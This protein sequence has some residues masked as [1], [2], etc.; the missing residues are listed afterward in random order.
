MNRHETHPE[1][2][3]VFDEAFARA[4]LLRM[5]RADVNAVRT[6]HYPPHPRVLDLCDELGFWVVLECDLETHGFVFVDWAGNPSDDPAWADGVPRPHRADGRA[7]QEPRQRR[8]WSLGN[9]AGTGSQPRRHG[10]LGAPPRPEPARALRGRP[11]LHLHRRLLADVPELPR[12]RGDRRRRPGSSPTCTGRPRRM[13]VRARPLVLCEYAHAMGNGP[14][15]VRHLRRPVRA[16]TPACTAGSSGSGATTGS[17]DARPPTAPPYYAYGGDFGEV[18]HDGNFVMDGMV[19]PDGTPTPG[20]AEWRAVNAPVRL[21]RRRV[22]CSVRNRQHSADTAGLRF[23]GGARGGRPRGRRV[24]IDAMPVEA[25][26][27]RPAGAARRA[28]GARAETGETWLTVRAELAHDTPWAPAGHV[29]ARAQCDLTPTAAAVPSQ[30][31]RPQRCARRRG[32]RRSRSVRPSST[33]PPA[34]SRASATSPSRARAWSCGGRPPTTTAATSAARTSSPPPRTPRRGRPA[35][36]RTSAGASA[37]WTGWCTASARVEVGRRPVV[38]RP[39]RRRPQ[40]LGV[41]VTYR[42]RAPRRRGAARRGAARPRAG[43]A[44][45]P[46]SASG[47]T[48]RRPGPGRWFGTGP[49]ECYPDTHDAASSDGS[50]PTWTG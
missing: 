27:D 26:R 10:R 30:P 35:R 1:R 45:G 17:C 33:S 32:R 25:G 42:Y 37:A 39:R 31:G 49:A 47:S 41:D 50:R 3:R 43:T 6:S 11:H 22:R 15:G 46:G 44:P 14:G 19:L 18:V 24:R 8:L 36:R 34:C 40:R 9:E 21:E 13:R 28:A 48:C 4:D 12:D 20:L 38:A 23:V 2:G 5:K 29:V 7:R 16:S